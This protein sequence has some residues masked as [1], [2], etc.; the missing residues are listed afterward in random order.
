MLHLRVMVIICEWSNNQS[1]I[2][3]LEIAVKLFLFQGFQLSDVEFLTP[4]A[5]DVVK[6]APMRDL[7]PVES[8]DKTNR[9]SSTHPRSYKYDEFRWNTMKQLVKLKNDQMKLPALRRCRPTSS[10]NVQLSVLQ[11]CAPWL[12]RLPAP[13]WTHLGWTKH[14]KIW[15]KIQTNTTKIQKNTKNAKWMAES[16]R[17]VQLQLWRSQGFILMFIWCSYGFIWVH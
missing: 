9:K 16:G 12:T 5:W 7:V 10:N 13:S 4:Q 11:R 17:A 15:Q 6:H 1:E 14:I 8:Q 3:N 2:W